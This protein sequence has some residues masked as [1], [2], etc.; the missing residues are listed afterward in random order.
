MLFRWR[1][2]YNS[3]E[4]LGFVHLLMKKIFSF[5]SEGPCG[6]GPSDLEMLQNI[7]IPFDLLSSLESNHLCS[8]TNKHYSEVCCML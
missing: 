6:F 7:S 3:R 8:L 1:I 2:K 5:F 4:N